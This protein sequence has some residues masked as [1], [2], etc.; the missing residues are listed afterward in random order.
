MT[1]LIDHKLAKQHLLSI[2]HIR[3]DKSSFLKTFSALPTRKRIYAPSHSCEAIASVAASFYYRSAVPPPASNLKT[4]PLP[5]ATPITHA[6]LLFLASSRLILFPN[7]T[8]SR[9]KS[10][11]VLHPTSRRLYALSCPP[12][13]HCALSAPAPSGIKPPF[14]SCSCLQPC[15][16]FSTSRQSLLNLLSS[17]AHGTSPTGF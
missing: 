1:F 10:L 2:Y 14:Y 9:R 16:I 6:Q 17:H 5:E 12:Y 13:Q 15:A 4:A 7:Q 3:S 11:P 8:E